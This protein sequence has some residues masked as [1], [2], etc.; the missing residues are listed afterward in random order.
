MA[1]LKIVSY[2][3]AFEQIA[4]ATEEGNQ[5]RAGQKAEQE[6]LF[7][8]FETI[9]GGQESLLSVFN[10]ARQEEG[11]DDIKGSI[12]TFN[13]QISSVKSLLDS[14][15][16]DI[17][18]R[19]RGSF[20][21][22]AQR[23]RMV[24]SEGGALNT[25]LG[26]LGSGLEPLVSSWNM[27]NQAVGDIVNL[28][29]KDQD[30]AV[31]GTRMRLDALP[32][33]FAREISGFNI[34]KENE[35]AAI[36]DKLKTEQ[37]LATAEWERLGQLE[38]EARAFEQQKQLATFQAQLDRQTNASANSWSKDLIASLTGKAAGAGGGAAPSI[39]DADS[40]YLGKIMAMDPNSKLS[41][42]ASLRRSKDPTAQRRFQLGKELGYWKF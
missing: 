37:N 36:M 20:T 38:S 21:T 35:L 9:R 33:R 5:M 2:N 23:N 16:E 3:P 4:R 1:D 34:S 39:A 19:T 11:I 17:S 40:E 27:S 24:A 22:D 29:S 42:I 26:R 12:G 25:Q 30:R 8:Q 18:S 14:L 7:K 10:R 13:T 6:N 15:D 41:L 31:E 32:E 28:T